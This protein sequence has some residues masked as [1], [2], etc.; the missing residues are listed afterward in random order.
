MNTIQIDCFLETAKCLNFSKAAANLYISQPTLS[1][2]ISLLEKELE[3]RLFVRNSFQGTQLT[4]A[5]IC[6]LDAFLKTREIMEDAIGHARNI[7][8][9]KILCLTFGLLEGQ[10][11]D[12][13][14]CKML[15]EFKV[16]NE[17][18]HLDVVKESFHPL[19]HRLQ[20]D[21]LDIIL[22]LNYDIEG[23]SGLKVCPFY[24]LPTWLVIPKD[25]VKSEDKDREYSLADFSHLPFI[26]TSENDSPVLIDMLHRACREAGFVPKIVFVDTLHEET[27]QLEMGSGI[28]GLN[29]YHSIFYS[30]NVSFVKVK[31]FVPQGFSL[32]WKKD[33]ENPAVKIFDDFFTSWS[34][35]HEFSL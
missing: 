34:K 19:L 20:N 11:M 30:P 22:T 35:N 33:T 26:C 25:S 18:V 17:D 15:N 31:E 24:T 14:L 13:H 4:Q 29:P 28:A 23:I 9:Q 10:M 1:R 12:E 6:L 2:N 21:E 8:R 16:N 27:L 3:V 7:S 5:G 32:A